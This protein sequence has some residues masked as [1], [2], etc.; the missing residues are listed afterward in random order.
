MHHFINILL[1]SFLNIS[2]ATENYVPFAAQDTTVSVSSEQLAD[3]IES[4]ARLLIG[5]P[6]RYGANGP[7]A[8][9]C[10]GFVR[11]I[12]HKF[13]YEL[14]RSS[15]DQFTDG[16]PVEGDYT[17]LQKGDIV[18]FSG[19]RN[20]KTPGHSGIFLKMEP[21]GQSFTFIHAARGGV[22]IS[23]SSEP[24]YDKRFLGARRII[25]DF[26][27]RNPSGINN[28]EYA[29]DMEKILPSRDTLNLESGD[30][31]IVMLSKGSWYLADNDGNLRKPAADSTL[32]LYSDGSWRIIPDSK[33]LIPGSAM[34]I[35][36]AGQNIEEHASRQETPVAGE[37]S[38]EEEY[39]VIRQGDTLSRIAVN[40]HTTVKKL[41]ELNGMTETTILKIGKKIRVR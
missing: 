25:P 33:V 4:Q 14:G 13:G 2:P 30:M 21:D 27:Q 28:E 15:R 8:F 22:R 34:Q 19:S 23:K 5:T 10:S 36:K 3:M 37:T 9:D 12:Y 16:R 40:H 11:F 7:R 24:Y 32:V 1:I 38:G 39:Y 20:S 31:R 35:Q 41:C 6:Y 17:K 18:T 26:I 29:E